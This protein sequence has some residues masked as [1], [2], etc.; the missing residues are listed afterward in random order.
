[1]NWSAFEM[2]LVPLAVVTVTFTV[3]EPAGAMAVIDAEELTVTFVA[4]A[5]PNATVAPGT[6][7]DPVMVTAV[8]AEPDEVLRAETVGSAPIDM[9]PTKH[10]SPWATTDDAEK[11]P[12]RERPEPTRA[13]GA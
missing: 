6:K 9:L 13:L 12:P 4:A 7:F 8:P 3:P 2:E 10:A 5:S 11:L 1:M